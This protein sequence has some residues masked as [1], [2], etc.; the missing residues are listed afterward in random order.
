MNIVVTG[1]RGFIGSVFC[2]RAT[3]QGCQVFALD[4]ESRGL[5][6]LGPFVTQYYRHDCSGGITEALD[7]FHLAERAELA[8]AAW[9]R[10]DA[11][12]HLAAGTG[13]LDR[14]YAELVGLNVEMTQRVYHDAVAAGAKAFVFPTTSLGL[15]E[16]LKDSPYVK[17]KDDAMRWL[18]D[19]DAP[20]RPW[21]S[22]AQ[23]SSGSPRGELPARI[24]IPVRFFNVTG[25]YK[26]ASEFRR[27]EVHMLPRL[28][29]AYVQKTPFVINGDDYATVDGTPGRDFINVV[30]LV[31]YLLFL[32]K[33]KVAN[34]GMG[35]LQG[36]GIFPSK[37][38][39]IHCGTGH[40][41]T[42]RQ[43]VELFRQHV[44]R[45]EYTIGPRRA[46]DT[47]GLQISPEQAHQYVCHV[48]GGMATPF[49][50]SLRD[51]AK[52]LIHGSRG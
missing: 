41:T 29:D 50:V 33:T 7:R 26:G 15:A 13:S 1:A 22:S 42:T 21:A 47:G 38:G 10:V 35:D 40:Q 19:V 25:A 18:L 3:E 49:W 44:G 32:I 31:E 51:E 2:R 37:D 39:A 27:K 28:V 45:V 46:Y 11:V 16:D 52:A 43:A 34:E 36:A 4:D 6:T 23:E 14:P 20:W 24:A 48:P 12:V 30:D 9:P 17:S 8:P 5:N